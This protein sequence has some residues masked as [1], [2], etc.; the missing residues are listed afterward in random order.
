MHRLS[1]DLWKK[2]IHL[3]INEVII[4]GN[5]TSEPHSDSNAID[6]PYIQN[7]RTLEWGYCIPFIPFKF[8]EHYVGD[9]DNAAISFDLSVQWPA[10][11]RWYGEFFLDDMLALWK[12]FSDDWGNKWAF[13]IGGN[14]FGRLLSRDI[15]VI[16]E[17]SRVEPWVYTHFSG[18]SHRYTH[19]NQNLGSP[20][21]P[22][23]QAAIFSFLMQISPLHEVGIGLR[24]TAWNGTVR[25]GSI[26]DVF[27]FEDPED[28]TRFFDSPTKRFL[29]PGTEWYLQPVLYWNFNLFS[30]ISLRTMGTVDILDK[31]GRCSLAIYGGFYF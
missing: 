5:T 30:M 22:N 10:G 13:T 2:R 25:G 24:H 29:G 26:T 21:G 8:L 17:Y 23:S 1:A 18:G 6:K 4:Y 27:Q 16:A 7:D 9:R 14:Y 11:W 19:F 20:M 28:S 31:R 3:G 15:T 12:L